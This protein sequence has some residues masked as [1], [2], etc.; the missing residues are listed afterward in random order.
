M[1]MLY[2]CTDETSSMQGGSSALSR[3]RPTVNQVRISPVGGFHGLRSVLGVSFSALTLLVGCQEG[4]PVHKG[5]VLPVSKGSVPEQLEEG[6][7]MEKRLTQ[8]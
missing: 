1:M 5:P 4:C 6:K 8:A 7:L 2:W 3:G